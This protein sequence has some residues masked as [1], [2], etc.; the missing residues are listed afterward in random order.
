MRRVEASA[1]RASRSR[2][3]LSAF[4]AANANP[5]TTSSTTSAPPTT[6]VPPTTAAG[7]TKA[8]AVATAKVAVV[9]TTTAKPKPATTTTA[10]PKPTT[11]VAPTTTTTT[12]PPNKQEGDASY[13]EARQPT[14]CA[15]R[16]IAFGTVVRVT[17]LANGKRTTCTVNDR[18]PYID[19]RIID[20]SPHSFSQ[21]APLEEGVIRVAIQW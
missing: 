17:N 6:V 2:A 10:K 7:T 14:T 16:T 20:L 19:G 3:E 15:H 9:T 12:A 1:A 5:T 18:G 8:P 13:F 21:L 11:T 4:E